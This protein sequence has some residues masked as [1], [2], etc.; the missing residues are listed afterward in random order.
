[1]TRCGEGAALLLAIAVLLAS[2]TARAVGV[3]E[4]ARTQCAACHGADGRCVSDDFP[5]LAG[6]H[7]DYLARALADYQHGA[8][9]NAIMQA[10]VTGLTADEITA[11]AEHFARLPGPLRVRR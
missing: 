5:A 1:M 6:Q 11:L 4:R 10:Q 7:A 8:R 3:E 2:G 9:R